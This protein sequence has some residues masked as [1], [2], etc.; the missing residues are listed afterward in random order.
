MNYLTIHWPTH[1]KACRAETQAT[2][3]D[4]HDLV[5]LIFGNRRAPGEDLHKTSRL[6]HP[7]STAARHVD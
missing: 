7:S 3:G 6:K 2:P 1:C 5:V 4:P